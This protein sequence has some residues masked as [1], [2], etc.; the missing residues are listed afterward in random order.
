LSAGH[1]FKD[2][3]CFGCPD[4]GFG[5]LIVSVDVVSDGDD[6]LFGILEDAAAKSVVGQVAEEAFHHVEP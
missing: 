4:E 1:L 5:I 2:V 3:V 6:E